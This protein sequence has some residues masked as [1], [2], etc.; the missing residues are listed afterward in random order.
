MQEESNLIREG[1]YWTEANKWQKGVHELDDSFP[2]HYVQHTGIQLSIQ[3]QKGL[4]TRGSQPMPPTPDRC[5]FDSV[6]M[7]FSTVLIQLFLEQSFLLQH[8]SLLPRQI[9]QQHPLGIGHGK[10][11]CPLADI[12]HSLSPPFFDMFNGWVPSAG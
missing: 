5:G 12:P 8:L 7:A 6:L 10:S 3:M 2:I 11:K 9:A 4:L 1:I